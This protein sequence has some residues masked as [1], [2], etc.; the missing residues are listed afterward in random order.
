MVCRQGS[1]ATCFLW[2]L[3]GI[4]LTLP[5]LLLYLCL[6]FPSCSIL[7]CNRPKAACLLTNGNRIYSQHTEGIPPQYMWPYLS[8]IL[9][10]L[11]VNAGLSR[12][13]VEQ[14]EKGSGIWLLWLINN[15]TRE[16]SFRKSPGESSIQQT[17]IMNCCQLLLEMGQP[18]GE[19]WDQYYY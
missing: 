17:F 10:Y 4:S 7:R 19:S 13:T 9:I 1:R 16:V 18:L 6:E 3:R 15:P 8:F 12:S 11:R 2:W 14:R 5:S